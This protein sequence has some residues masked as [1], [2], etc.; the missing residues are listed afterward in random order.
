MRLFG[1]ERVQ[2]AMERMNLDED[3]P[4]ES[5][6]LTCPSSRPRPPWSPGTSS[7]ES[8]CWNTTT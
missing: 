5:K 4:I 2:A 1:G 6:M 8:P 7:P 3:T